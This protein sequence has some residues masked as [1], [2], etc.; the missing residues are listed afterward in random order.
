MRHSAPY[1][2]VCPMGNGYS[3]RGLARVG[4]LI[5]AFSGGGAEEG[6]GGSFRL[7]AGTGNVTANITIAIRPFRNEI[8]GVPESSSES[9]HPASEQ[10]PKR[11]CTRDGAGKGRLR[12]PARPPPR[13]FLNDT[14]SDE[15]AD[16]EPG[17]H[18]DRNPEMCSAGISL[19]P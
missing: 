19:P 15:A 3:G 12:I 6:A 13:H 14:P 4:A 1:T 18:N 2:Y 11:H 16:A 8:N 9:M 7:C 5:I 17:W 10:R